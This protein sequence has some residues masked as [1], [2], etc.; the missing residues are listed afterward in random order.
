MSADELF[1]V[2]EEHGKEGVDYITVHVG[3]TLKNLEV[4]RNSPRTT[5]IVSRGG[6]LMAAWMLHRGEEN[7]LYARFDDLLDIARTYDMT[8]SLGDGLRPGSSPTA[9]TGP[10]SQSSSPS[11]SSWKG[12]EGPGSRPW[13][14]APGTS[15]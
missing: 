7:P 15:P 3:V 2:I 4:Y 1:Q 13:W 8:L 11:G 5:G 9:P 14:K 6:G 10:R 12:P